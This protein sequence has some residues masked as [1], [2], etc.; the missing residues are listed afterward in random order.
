MYSKS[1]FTR[2]TTALIIITGSS[3]LQN[4][5]AEWTQVVPLPLQATIHA[6]DYFPADETVICAADSGFIYLSPDSGLSWDRTQITT[7]AWYDVSC[8]GQ[9]GVLV[10]ES[11]HTRITPNSAQTWQTPPLFTGADL[12]AADLLDETR[13]IVGG[14]SGELWYTTNSGSGWTAIAAPQELTIYDIEWIGDS[15]LYVA[16]ENTLWKTANLGGSWTPLS[17]YDMDLSDLFFLNADTGFACGPDIWTNNRVYR[18]LD[19]GA[20][21][22]S[23]TTV[24]NYPMAI[25]AQDAE[26]VQ[27]VTRNGYLHHSNGSFTGSWT[28][29]HIGGGFSDLAAMPN[30]GRLVA[31]GGYDAPSLSGPG[32]ISAYSDDGGAS[33]EYSLFQQRFPL[34]SLYF[35]TDLEGWIAG[36][37]PFQVMMPH[38]DII[39]KTTDGGTT[40]E[41]KLLEAGGQGLT[42]IQF[43]DDLNGVAS[44]HSRL[45]RT[46]DGG[47]SWVPETP[48]SANHLSLVD[49]QE[50]WTCGLVTIKH[51]ANAGSTWTSQSVPSVTDYLFG[52][53]FTD[54]Q[55][56]WASGYNYSPFR[57]IILITS[58]GGTNWDYDY[59]G[60]ASENIRDIGMWDSE[61]GT[62]VCTNGTILHKSTGSALWDTLTVPGVE[63]LNS[64]VYQDSVHLWAAGGNGDVIYSTDGGDSWLVDTVF[65]G[66]AIY[67]VYVRGDYRYVATSNGELFFTNSAPTPV[68]GQPGHPVIP[69]TF[70]LSKPYPNPF[71]PVT[72]IGYTLPKKSQVSL[73]IY[74]VSGRQVAEL[75]DGWRDA[76]VHEVE[77]DASEL[78]SGVYL[79]RLQA[80][81]YS[82]VQKMVLMK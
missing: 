71:N 26:N 3:F 36:G 57:G 37:T 50:G 53:D 79:C 76:G 65:T 8:Y 41:P 62:A 19:G 33:W 28:P 54:T 39:L 27:V 68:I 5:R 15:T 34:R 38:P 24:Y 58:N 59:E 64:V 10:G 70:A 46:T 45:Y 29:V 66:Y 25:A 67:D 82:A 49:T 31:V 6:V 69:A 18:T 63:S 13:Y 72:M 77:F 17:T 32:A 9:S 43:F 74:D 48:F 30:T 52:I 7:E 21:W 11:G 73:S 40:W 22:D 60:S 42:D 44:G 4:A 1:F 61:N 81:N 51:T 56:G 12:Y 2:Y 55:H 80:S 47:D 14:D 75:V 20:S 16:A 35:R 23:V 78:A